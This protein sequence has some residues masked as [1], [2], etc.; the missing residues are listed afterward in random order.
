MKRSAAKAAKKEDRKK[1]DEAAEE[2]AEEV[3]PREVQCFA[4]R[5]CPKGDYTKAKWISLRKYFEE[6]VKP[7]LKNYSKHE[8]MG[9]WANHQNQYNHTK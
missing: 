4:R 8:D 2:A 1:E 7:Y 6:R 5:K 3:K 9:R